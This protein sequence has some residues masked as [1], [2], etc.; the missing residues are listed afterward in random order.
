MAL[1]F[2][3]AIE[4]KNS[5]TTYWSRDAQIEILKKILRPTRR[6]KPKST[7]LKGENGHE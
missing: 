6:I 1:F 3:C 4:K 5:M 2:Y 7:L